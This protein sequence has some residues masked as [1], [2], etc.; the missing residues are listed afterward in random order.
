MGGVMERAWRG[1]GGVG[2]RTRV[3]GSLEPMAGGLSD[4]V[5]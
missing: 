4:L 3:T 2:R 5:I 1:H